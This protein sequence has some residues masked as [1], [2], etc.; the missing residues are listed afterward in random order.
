[1]QKFRKQ[2]VW[3]QPYEVARKLIGKPATIAATVRWITADSV[4]DQDTQIGRG[5]MGR[6]REWEGGRREVGEKGRKREG[7]RAGKRGIHR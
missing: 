7:G 6:E 5:E 1:M 3:F 4:E 2:K